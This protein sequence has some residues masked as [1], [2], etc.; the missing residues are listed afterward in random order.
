MSD[1][2]QLWDRME[3]ESLTWYNRFTKFRLMFPKRSVAAVFHEEHPQTALSLV[4]S[5]QK[6]S[7]DWYEIAE[8]WK[9]E[10]RS[11]AFDASL[12]AEEEKIRQR[13]IHSGWA[14][15]Y[16]RILT[17]TETAKKLE[18]MLSEKSSIWVADVKSVGTG[19]DAERVDLVQFNDALFKEFREY[20]ADIAEE[21]GGRVKKK[22]IAITSLPPDMYAG[23]GPND[24]GVDK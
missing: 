3:G 5:R 6:V 7:G 13:V 9:W 24:D 21:V 1:E 2:Q 8:Q 12:V 15:D 14:L 19:P 22:D 11:E 10:E 16:E 4:K 23:I 18:V 17:L 20:M